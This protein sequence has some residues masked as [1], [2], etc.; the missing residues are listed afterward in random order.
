MITSKEEIKIN[1]FSI[2]NNLRSKGIDVLEES[3]RCKK[4]L[5]RQ[6][7]KDQVN[8]IVDVHK[9]I[10]GCRFEGFT[11][12]RSIIGKELEEYKTMIPSTSTEQYMKVVLYGIDL[13]AQLA[14]TPRKHRMHMC[15]QHRSAPS[16]IWTVERHGIYL[17]KSDIFAIAFSS[18]LRLDQ[19]YD[20]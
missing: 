12:I 7:I 16:V 3:F 14:I 6:D 19:S 9:I 15:T 13:V 4:E 5:D 1:E 11:R 17:I 18:Q 8:L 2:K 20:Q 10:S